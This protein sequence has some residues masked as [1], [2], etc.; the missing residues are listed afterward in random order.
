MAQEF[1]TDDLCPHCGVPV[2]LARRGPRCPYCGVPFDLPA[3]SPRRRGY[4]TAFGHGVCGLIA[5]GYGGAVVALSVDRTITLGDPRLV[6]FPAAG[7][8]AC[9]AAA[10]GIGSHLASD[11]RRGYE[12]T[13]F[14]LVVAVL[15]M[16]CLCLTTGVGADTVLAAGAV[17]LVVAIPVIWRHLYDPRRRRDAGGP[18]TV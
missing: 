18:R 3:D 14:S 10:A 12:A 13:L 1:K 6:L 9:A 7:A 11:V 8:V 16:F 2:P 4:L 5:G 15:S 17:T